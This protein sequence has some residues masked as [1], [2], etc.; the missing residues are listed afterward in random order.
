MTIYIYIL[1]RNERTRR[2]IENRGSDNCIKIYVENEGTF[3][4][5]VT[6]SSK[7]AFKLLT[8]DLMNLF[9]FRR[10]TNV[11]LKIGN[12]ITRFD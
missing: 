12:R 5:N 11:L 7:H 4:E 3:F 1:F 8:F 10:P 9:I 2:E 6:S